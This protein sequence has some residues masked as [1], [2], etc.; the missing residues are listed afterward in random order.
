MVEERSRC[1]IDGW[2]SKSTWR[3]IKIAWPTPGVAKNVRGAAGV[4]H[5]LSTLTNVWPCKSFGH[6]LV[7][8]VFGWRAHAQTGSEVQI[9][10]DPPIVF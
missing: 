4:G 8:L 3:E 5:A 1:W 2:I 6:S 10:F 7:I 9:S